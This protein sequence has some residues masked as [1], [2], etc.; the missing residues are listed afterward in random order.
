MSSGFK[1]CLWLVLYEAIHLSILQAVQVGKLT[2]RVAKLLLSGVYRIRAGA[3]RGRMGITEHILLQLPL[4][5]STSSA[6]ESAAI[7]YSSLV[8]VKS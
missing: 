5:P 7:L 6:P 8:F 4:A 3:A 1:H 2:V